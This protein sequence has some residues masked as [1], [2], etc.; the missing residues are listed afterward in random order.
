MSKRVRY[1]PRT[2]ALEIDQYEF[3][4]DSDHHCE[5]AALH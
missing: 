5:L 4:A 2:A 1:F 3:V